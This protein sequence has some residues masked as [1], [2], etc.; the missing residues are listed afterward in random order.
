MFLRKDDLT[1]KQ[2]EHMF[3]LEC[4]NTRKIIF[5]KRKHAIKGANYGTFFVLNELG[6]CIDITY[7][8]AII[9]EEDM[10]F[11]DDGVRGIDLAHVDSAIRDLSEYL[12][13]DWS[14][15]KLY[16]LE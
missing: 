11:L 9:F 14:D 16:V 13:G 10:V 12:Y 8:L 5:L 4:S 6:Q 15:I 7:S 3:L 2:K 1:E